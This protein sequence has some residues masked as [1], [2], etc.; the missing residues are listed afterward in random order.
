MYD[1]NKLN[2]ALRL[3]DMKLDQRKT[4]PINLVVCGGSSLIITGLVPRTTTDVDVLAFATLT[5]G[6]KIQI[7]EAKMLSQELV[8]SAREVAR[9]LGLDEKWLNNMPHSEASFGLPEGFA[10][11]LKSHSYGKILTIYFIDRLDQIHFKLHAAVDRGLGRHVNDLIALKPTETEMEKAARW[12]LT[13]DAGPQFIDVLK[14]TLRS[15]GYGAVAD[16]I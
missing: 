7:T 3:L 2:S 8:E 1:K 10:E 16:R 15:I 11:R 6:G 9:D 4:E 12:V 14:Q 5:P 13:Q